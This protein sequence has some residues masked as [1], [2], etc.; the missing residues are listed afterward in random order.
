MD[1]TEEPREPLKTQ[2]QHPEEVEHHENGATKMFR[3]VKARAKKFKNSLTKHGQ[4]QEQ[5]HDVVEDDDDDEDDELES[6]GNSAHGVTG[7]PETLS[8]PRETSVP[9]PEEIVP[10]GTKVFPVV[11]SDYSKPAEPVS[12]DYSKP[13]EPVSSDYSKPPEPVPIHDSSYANE[14]LFNHPKTTDTS[15]KEESRDVPIRHPVPELSD[16]EESRET[17]HES[18]NTPVSLLSGTEDVSR[19]FPPSGEDDHLGG[20]RKVNFETPIKIEDDPAVPVGGSDYLSGVSSYESKV[21]DPTKAGGEGGVPEI[22]ESFGLMKVTD[23]S[24]DQKPGQGFE[25]DLSRRSKEFREFDQ[26]FNSVL[27][28]DSP[29]KFSGESEAELEKDS[30]TRSHDFDMKTESGMDKNS[31]SRSHEFDLK[32][33]SGLEKNYPMGFGSESG[34]EVGRDE[35]E[36]KIGSGRNEYSPES[37][38]GLGAPLGGNFPVRSHELDVKEESGVDKDTPTGFD[39]EPD[40]LAKGRPGYGDASEERNLPTARSDDVKVETELGRDLSTETHDGLLAPEHSRPNER[41]EFEESRG[42]FEETKDET[43]PKTYAQQFASMLGYSGEIPE[44]QKTQA[45]RTVD[46]EDEK[47]TPVNVKDEET[48]SAVTRKLPFSGGESGVEETEQGDKKDV[49]GRDYL[50]EKLTPGEEDKALSEVIAEKLKIGGEEEKKETTAT[51][52]VD[53]TVEKTPTEK[54]SVEGEHGEAGEE[55]VKG[56]GMVGMIKGWFGGAATEEVKPKSPHSV[57]DSESTQSLG[58]TVGTKGFPESSGSELGET[59]VGG[60]AVPVQ[61]GV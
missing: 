43:K 36:Q 35:F 3:K 56:G 4:G 11:S 9:A 27:G 57:E 14:G 51:K 33:E 7:K 25:R 38:T 13:P 42:D 59:G 29:S 28:K 55:E 21:S 54:V 5:D 10:P 34:A 58:T 26:D 61:R 6:E 15:D 2:Q 19:T 32:T 40:F 1:Q 50:A 16:R 49:S 44:G 39:G 22:A 8:H 60:G 52:D 12:S 30:S 48:E 47:L 46:D 24:A 53:V 17:H 45:A 37:D 18:L 20:Q 41:D 31:P 23:E